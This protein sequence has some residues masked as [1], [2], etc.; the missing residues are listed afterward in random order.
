[1]PAI[2]HRGHREGQAGAGGAHVEATRRAAHEAFVEDRL[3]CEVSVE[4]LDVNGALGSPRQVD[5]P[6]LAVR[7]HA[8]DEVRGL[9]PDG[10]PDHRIVPAAEHAAVDRTLAARPPEQT[11]AEGAV[12]PLHLAS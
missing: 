4:D 11:A 2:V 3:H 8:L 6:D 7:V 1:M 9:L 10:A 12:H 5:A